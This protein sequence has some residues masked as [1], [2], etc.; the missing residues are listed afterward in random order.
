MIAVIKN[1]L[2]QIDFLGISFIKNLT[3]GILKL[4]IGISSS[5]ILIIMNAIYN[6]TLCLAKLVSLTGNKLMGKKHHKLLPSSENYELLIQFI[7]GASI[8]VIGIILFIE[9]LHTYES[10]ETLHYSMY[11]VYLLTLSTFIKLGI[12]LYGT[13]VYREKKGELIFT[14]K[15]TNI[16]DALFSLVLTQCAI[17]SMMNTINASRYNG[18][19]GIFTSI[20]VSTIGVWLMIYMT[21]NHNF[22]KQLVLF[23]E[24]L[25]SL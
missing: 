13:I 16:A 22:R 20:M 24:S 19:F 11:G 7:M 12:S 15:L 14:A 5:S 18:L 21:Q 6:L 2:K 9:S 3:I 1:K 17:L 4:L 25:R 23:K 8:L 10:G